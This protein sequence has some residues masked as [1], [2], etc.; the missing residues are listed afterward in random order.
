MD[1]VRC[2][3]TFRRKCDINRHLKIKKSCNVIYINCDRQLL[4]KNYDKYYKIYLQSKNQTNSNICQTTVDKSVDKIKPKSICEYCD[5]VFDHKCNYYTHKRKYCHVIKDTKKKEKNIENIIQDLKND[6]EN[7][8]EQSNID[9]EEKFNEKLESKIDNLQSQFVSQYQSQNTQQYGHINNNQNVENQT[10]NYTIN[11]YGS[12]DLSKIDFNEWKIIIKKDYDMI[13]AL[14]KKIH[15][16]MPDNHNIYL[17]SD[18]DKTI[19]IFIDKWLRKDKT[20][21]FSEMILEKTNILQD[22]IDKYGDKFTES[23]LKRAQ[24]I[25]DYCN[26]DTEE[27]QRIKRESKL[28]L[29]NNNDIIEPS[30][31][32]TLKK[33]KT[34]TI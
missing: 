21:F 13:P 27:L 19:A 25:L 5:K 16:D 10:I 32:N 9:L 2:G 20:R 3:K 24:S 8:L 29:I 18:K 11:N 34:I 22:I 33:K 4:I 7:R 23:E 30:Y 28:E 15:V 17:P 6:Y 26:Y 12:E 31:K 1:C 14:I